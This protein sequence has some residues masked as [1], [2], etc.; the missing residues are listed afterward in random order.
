[1]AIKAAANKNTLNIVRTTWKAIKNWSLYYN[2][3]LKQNR[4]LFDFIVFIFKSN[5]TLLPRTPSVA[6]CNIADDRPN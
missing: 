1:M 5:K 6:T 4:F 3:M 2:S